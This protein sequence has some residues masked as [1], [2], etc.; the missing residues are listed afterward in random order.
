MDNIKEE[1]LDTVWNLI[2]EFGDIIESFDLSSA[3]IDE[4][5][6]NTRNIVDKAY[7]KI[8]EL[9]EKCDGDN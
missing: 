9:L 3:T 4:A 1:I 6:R 7:A 2:D 8:E 5:E